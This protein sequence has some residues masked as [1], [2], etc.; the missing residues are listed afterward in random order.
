MSRHTY[1]KIDKSR[2]YNER[3]FKPSTFRAWL[4]TARFRWAAR[5]I[6]KHTTASYSL[7]EIGCFDGRLLRH[8]DPLPQVYDGYDADWEEGLSQ[9]QSEN[10]NPGHWTFHYS[11]HY[12]D[13][14]DLPNK[15]YDVSVS[16]E[17]L[18]HIAPEDVQGYFRE[19][20]RLSRSTFICTVPNEM[21][22]VFLIK[23]V[24][25]KVVFGSGRDY[26][27]S[28]VVWATL[29]ITNKVERD[30]HK[31]FNYNTLLEQMSEFFEIISIENVQLPWMPNF[32]AFTIGIVACPRAPNPHK[33]PDGA[34]T[35]RPR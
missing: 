7:L 11:T 16:L 21:G 28:E 22:L 10:L 9:A 14:I 33:S 17:T 35:R 12:R 23:Y 27:L 15:S 2:E 20:S 30:E 34:V 19:L 1:T 25:K 18:E 8:I 13:L 5:K 26:K 24:L 3:L 31:G 32:V 29:G 4:H 6:Q